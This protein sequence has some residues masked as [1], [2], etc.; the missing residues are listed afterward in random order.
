VEGLSGSDFAKNRLQ[1][2]LRTLSGEVT[3]EEACAEL[4]ISRTRF[5][6]LRQSLLEGMVEHLEPRPAGRPSQK[7]EVPEEVTNLERRIAQLELE[8]EASKIRTELNTFLPL[9]DRKKS[10][11]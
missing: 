5:Y 2:V 7:P 4:Q 1:Q 8:L 11:R 10:G 6:D 3:I 9:Y